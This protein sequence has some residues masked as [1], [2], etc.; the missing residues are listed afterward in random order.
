MQVSVYINSGKCILYAV[1]ND[2]AVE[3]DDLDTVSTLHSMQSKKVKKGGSR[4]K[5]DKRIP[6]LSADGIICQHPCFA[7]VKQ[8]ILRPRQCDV[9]SFVQTVVRAKAE[10]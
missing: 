10:F 7:V 1:D 2:Y 9:L 3:V 8:L 4:A 5:N 6:R